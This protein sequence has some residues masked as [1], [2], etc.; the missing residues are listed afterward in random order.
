MPIHI[1][2]KVL[3]SHAI[4]PWLQTYRQMHVRASINSLVLLF[5]E[6][7]ELPQ[8]LKNRKSLQDHPINLS[9][10]IVI[11]L[12]QS[13][14]P[15]HQWSIFMI[16]ILIMLLSTLN[17]IRVLTYSSSMSCLLNLNLISETFWIGVRRLLLLSMLEK[18]N[19]FYFIIHPF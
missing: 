1:Q 12:E 3:V 11:C 14:L 7:T 9:Y 17:E 19:L 5:L 2:S 6:S 18:L 15:M 16:L 13:F 10:S 8:I 4:F